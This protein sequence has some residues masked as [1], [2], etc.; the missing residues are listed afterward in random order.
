M[1]IATNALTEAEFYTRLEVFLRQLEGGKPP[2]E[3]YLDTSTVGGIRHV[4]IGIG[5]DLYSSATRD[6]VF[7]AMGIT[8]TATKNALLAIINNPPNSGTESQIKAA[9]I[10]QMNAAYGQPFVMT[11]AQIDSVF[12]TIATTEVNY[13]ISH[14]GL[15]YSDELVALVSAKFNGVFGSGVQ[16]ALSL[17]DPYQARAEAWYQIRYVH[18]ADQNESRRY[19]EASIFGLYDSPSGS[20]SKEEAVGIYKMYTHHYSESYDNNGGMINY[21]NAKSNDIGLSNGDLSAMGAAF[22]GYSTQKLE[23]ELRR[24]ADT[25]ET[26]FLKPNNLTLGSINPL[27]IQVC[28]D[29]AQTPKADL[30]GE[31]DTTRTGYIDDLLIGDAN[32]NTLQ[33]QSG[34]DI[35]LGED[36]N[37]TLDGGN[38]N[39]MLNG[40]E[41]NDTLN[42]EDGN[43]TLTGGEGTD[44]YTFTDN[45]GIDLIT[46]SDGLGSIT[47]DGQTLNSASQK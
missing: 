13:V 18:A 40:G 26:E 43:D 28:Y 19:S 25:I 30:T 36:G 37:D 22:S 27:N 1:T 4:T 8:D 11:D 38:G 14:T 34:N 16:A 9:L 33:G 2:N 35:L 31:D 15:P 42:G 6:L 39:D 7:T 47:V 41:S 46:D 21:D 5:F 32:G 20:V 45:Y 17:A 24:A 3:P 12:K 23:L 44:T 10:Q 29:D